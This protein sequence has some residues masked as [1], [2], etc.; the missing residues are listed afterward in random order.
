MGELISNI[1]LHRIAISFVSINKLIL[2]F[3]IPDYRVSS[4][5]FSS[6]NF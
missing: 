3:L 2:A 1:A 5:D 4:S 6:E